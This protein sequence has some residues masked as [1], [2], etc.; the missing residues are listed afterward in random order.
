MYQ[1]DYIMRTIRQFADMLAALLFGARAGGQD[2]TF[3]D[4]N[5]L[6]L[7]FVG[8]NLDV[9]TALSAPQLVSLHSAT[10]TLDVTKV[11]ISARLLYQ[12]AEQE[13]DEERALPLKDKALSLL[14]EVR[15]ELN[16]YLNEE[17]EVL[18]K[19][20]EQDLEGRRL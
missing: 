14:L 8:L 9:L 17:H 12:L 13:N 4:L 2:V 10:G 15:K 20:L 3:N 18:T 11:Y 1:T 16:G 5:D 19:G 6:S 7:T